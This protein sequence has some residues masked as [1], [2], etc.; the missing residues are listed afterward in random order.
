LST[1]N[2]T[3]V[4][5]VGGVQTAAFVPDADITPLFEAAVQATDEAVINAM[6]A[7]RSM[8]GRDGHTVPALPHAPLV[9]LLKSFGRIPA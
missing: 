3:A 2:A 7:N 8:T 6:I 5:A 1:A 4:D 9:E